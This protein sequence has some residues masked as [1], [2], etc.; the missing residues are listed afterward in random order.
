MKIEIACWQCDTVVEKEL[1]EV[2][3]SRRLGRQL[4]C[5][6]SCSAVS[7]NAPRK[8]QVFEAACP[9]CD[10]VFETSTHNKAKRHCSPSC[11][12]KGSMTAGRRAAQREAGLQHAENLH[13]AQALG[14][15]KREAWKY[16]AL[17]KALRGRQHEFE[18]RL[19][20][21][22]FD[23]ALLDVDVLVEFDGPYHHSATQRALDARKDRAARRHG[24]TVQRRRVK[25]DAVIPPTV[26]DGL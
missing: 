22:V 21:F 13:R 3:R 6:R 14:L 9:V 24:F 11:A 4:F 2:N 18:F 16:V 19:G 10:T 15:K 12:S 26:L 8:S 23:L 20:R 5:S 1:G 17:K 25:P 7:A